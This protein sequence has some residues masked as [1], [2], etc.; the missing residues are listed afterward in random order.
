MLGEQKDTTK[1]G[2]IHTYERKEGREEQGRNQLSNFRKN[3][4]SWTWSSSCVM[5][6][7]LV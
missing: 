7:Y 4:N 6:P 3:M 2:I 5:M 1:F